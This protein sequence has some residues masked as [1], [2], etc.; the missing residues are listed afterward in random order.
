M[1]SKKIELFPTLI[2]EYDL[3]NDIDPLEITDILWNITPNLNKE[4][5]LSL[6]DNG[7]HG[8]QVGGKSSYKAGRSILKHPKLSNLANIIDQAA[9]DY[10]QNSDFDIEL[11]DTEIET[12]WT[13]IAFKDSKVI[14]HDH[15]GSLFSCVY[16]PLFEK[17][18]ANLRFANPI[19]REL[20]DRIYKRFYNT[21]YIE[22]SIQQG[23]LYIFPGW[24][25]HYTEENTSDERIIISANW[26]LTR[27]YYDR[28]KSNTGHV[29]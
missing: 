11:N 13:N 10:L 29:V 4:Y 6:I 21:K 19:P 5:G 1:I 8:L 12:S 25:K 26:T 16:Y 2:K 18:S 9:T 20:D 22:M 3:N 14:M 28:H 17:G 7:L 15:K 24:L 27:E 23:S